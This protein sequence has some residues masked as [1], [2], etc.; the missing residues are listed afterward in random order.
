MA[1]GT[2]GGASAGQVGG[3]R[4]A[5]TRRGTVRGDGNAADVAAGRSG[6]G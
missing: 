3:S 6:A 5:G 1:A 4:G 2:L